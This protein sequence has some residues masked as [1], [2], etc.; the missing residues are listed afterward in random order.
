MIASIFLFFT[1][2]VQ[3]YELVHLVGFIMVIVIF[4]HREEMIGTEMFRKHFY[5]RLMFVMLLYITLSLFWCQDLLSMSYSYYNSFTLFIFYWVTVVFLKN[6]ERLFSSLKIWIIA[7]LGYAI[8]RT[9][10]QPK[11]VPGESE[12]VFFTSK[13]TISSLI[14]FSIFTL[15]PVITLKAK[16]IPTFLL[17]TAL[18]ILLAVNYGIGSRAGFGGLIIGIIIYLFIV[19][20]KEL[21]RFKRFTLKFFTAFIILFLIACIFLV[22]LLF[23]HLHLI[24]LPLPIPAEYSTILFRF[25]QWDYGRQMLEENHA[26]LFGLGLSG[27]STLYSS[28]YPPGTEMTPWQNH[29]HSIYV[30]V[31]CD[32][33]IIGYLIFTALMISVFLVLHKFILTSRNIPL[34]ILAAALYAGIF[35]FL[36]HGLVD[37]SLME[38][39]LWVFVGMSIALPLIDRSQNYKSVPFPSSKSGSPF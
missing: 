22:P 4:T 39:R 14:N 8:V 36:I 1:P 3:G 35:S 31:F 17:Y 27:Y 26:Y 23:M 28:Y 33:G 12:A 32:F 5:N 2:V 19:S 21:T 20:K 37:W 16:R 34:K 38:M 29:P 10:F 18:I 7:G 13:N 9:I 25:E 15:L 24:R 30:H 6:E 11:P